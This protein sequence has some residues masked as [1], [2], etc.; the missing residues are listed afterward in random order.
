MSTTL[1]DDLWHGVMVKW[2]MGAIYAPIKIIGSRQVKVMTRGMSLFLVNSVLQEMKAA[3][4]VKIDDGVD[5]NAALEK[6]LEVELNWGIIPDKKQVEILPGEE[7]S[8][9]FKFHSCPYGKLCNEALS[10][11]LSRGDFNK[12]TIP[13]LRMET[14]S[15]CM[16]LINKSKRAY[17]LVQFAPGAKCEC[18][19]LPPRKR[20]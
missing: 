4:T 11:L 5:D 17:S 14:Y 13:C 7:D 8:V 18:K 10:G 15:S 20:R 2:L 19:L 12:K 3:G 16:T 9:N 6:Y 1:K